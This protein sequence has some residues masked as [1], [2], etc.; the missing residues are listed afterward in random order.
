MGCVCAR[1]S[2]VCVVL[3][4]WLGCVACGCVVLVWY[5]CRVCIWVCVGFASVLRLC[6][7]CVAFVL[8]LCC[9][10]VLEFVVF[11]LW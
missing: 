2:V 5:V 7:V 8:R 3:V 9:A 4:L 11:V 10:C 1:G 6:C